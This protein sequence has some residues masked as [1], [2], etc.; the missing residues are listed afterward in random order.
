MLAC[1]SVNDSESQRQPVVK[2]CKSTTNAT[3]QSGRTSAASLLV[4]FLPQ[5][6][7]TSTQS[8]LTVNSMRY[9]LDLRKLELY[10]DH[11]VVTNCAVQEPPQDLDTD[12]VKPCDRHLGCSVQCDRPKELDHHVEL[13]S[14][15]ES[16]LKGILGQAAGKVLEKTRLTDQE[17]DQ[18]GLFG[19]DL[20]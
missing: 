6:L 13:P 18:T 15:L 3:D 7:F 1:L 9:T 2:L 17:V 12:A 4:L 19:L 16:F 20:P 10:G 8:S 14:T 11:H 5:K